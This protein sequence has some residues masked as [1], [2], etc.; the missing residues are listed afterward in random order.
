ME[1]AA[2]GSPIETPPAT[3][4]VKTMPRS[5]HVWLWMFLGA[6]VISFFL[7][8]IS[9]TGQ[10]PGRG[11]EVAWDALV[12]SFVTVKGMW[13]IFFPHLWAVWVNLFMLLAPFEIRRVGRGQGRVFAVLFL[14]A[15]TIPIAIAYSPY[16][17]D[18]SRDLVG[19]FLAG[20]YLWEFSSIATAGLFVRNLWRNWAAMLPSA[21]LMGLLLALPIYRG[22]VDFLP[23]PLKRAMA[24][25]S[26]EVPH[27]RSTTIG[28]FD[29]SPNPSLVG[30]LV[31]FTATT[32]AA[33]DSIPTG[34]V[35]FVE[36][37]TVIGKVHTTA[38]VA[39]FSINSL[40]TGEHFITANFAGDVT[41]SYRGSTSHELTQ[42]VNDPNDM[43]TQTLLTLVE[44]HPEQPPGQIGFTVKVRVTAIGTT[45]PIT[46]G[47]VVL[48]MYG[49]GT[50]LTLDQDGAATLTVVLPAAGWRGYRLKAIY[51]GGRGYQASM[52]TLTLQ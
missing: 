25:T 15:T 9:I 8:A 29:S 37:K 32:S 10:R 39:T 48:F 30:N 17:Q 40:K 6:W 24:G 51:H 7:P 49:L 44:R 19:R 21:V 23:S 5:V 38:G 26:A 20:F 52:S 1:P 43:G 11:W 16:P 12:L 41:T 3:A 36:G 18:H 47:D 27:L 34:T 31:T 50:A 4:S 13:L 46:A 35:D 33:D 2:D 42:L 28:L 14:L 45:R 22:E